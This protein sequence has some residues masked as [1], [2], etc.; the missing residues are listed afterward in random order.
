MIRRAEKKDIPDVGRLLEQVLEV[1]ASA[2][3]DIF[4][5]GTKK[6]TDEELEALFQDDSRP[7][8]VY[9]DEAGRVSGHAFCVFEETK[10][11]VN[12][13]DKKTL[14]IDDIC[15][16]EHCRRQHIGEKLYEYVR[17]FAQENGCDR[18]TLNVWAK[19]DS[20]ERF[21]RAMGMH[22]LKVMMEE[23]L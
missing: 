10:G 2:W 20:A 6:Y 12:M 9:T 15:V 18:I 19:N 14:Y 7:V 5:S 8:F 16:D 1:H 21:Y 23:T 4:I 17:A 3:P 13:Y 22:P 11:V